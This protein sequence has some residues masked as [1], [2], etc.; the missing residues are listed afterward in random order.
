MREELLSL[1]EFSP[2]F[3]N[4]ITF[5]QFVVFLGMVFKALVDGD[6]AKWGFVAEGSTCSGDNCP[7]S[8]NSSVITGAVKVEPVNPVS[9]ACSLLC[10]AVD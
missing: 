7:L 1:P 10:C 6:I 8:A 4:F 5:V 3:I 9:R 2:I